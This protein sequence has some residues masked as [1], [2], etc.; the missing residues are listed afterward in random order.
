MLYKQFDIFARGKLAIPITRG[1][2]KTVC[3]FPCDG[4]DDETNK[5]PS[6]AYPIE[7]S[8]IAETIDWLEYECFKTEA[9]LVRFNKGVFVL[10]L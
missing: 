7:I 6:W 5:V 1:K 8:E 4:L 10:F 9:T 3:F 2:T